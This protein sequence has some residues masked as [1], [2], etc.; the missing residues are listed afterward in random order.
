MVFH[1]KYLPP[2]LIDNHDMLEIVFQQCHGLMQIPHSHF[3][4]P[5]NYIKRQYYIDIAL[6]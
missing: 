2:Q 5:K 4:K 6:V 3:L 1:R